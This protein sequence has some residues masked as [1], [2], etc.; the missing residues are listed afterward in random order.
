MKSIIYG[1]VAATVLAFLTFTA[2]AKPVNHLSAA[3]ITAISDTGKMAKMSKKDTGKMAKMSK[4]KMA[5]MSKM[6]KPKSKMA[7]KDT[8]GKM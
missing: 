3:R 4:A 7:K 1:A 6:D 5:K 2:D 8:T